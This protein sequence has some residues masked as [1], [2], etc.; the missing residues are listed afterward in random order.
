MTQA[1][2]KAISF[3]EVRRMYDVEV[4]REDIDDYV[5]N[6]FW[7]LKT[8]ADLLAT[9]DDY[10]IADIGFMAQELIKS[11]MEKACKPLEFLCENCGTFEIVCSRT[12]QAGRGLKEGD[13]LCM[14]LQ[15]QG[16]DPGLDAGVLIARIAQG[17]VHTGK[18]GSK[19]PTINSGDLGKSAKMPLDVL[20]TMLGCEIC[21]KKMDKHIRCCYR[22]VETFAD[23]L[24]K[25][26]DRKIRQLGFLAQ[27]LIKAEMT[28]SLNALYFL[29]D[30]YGQHV[31]ISAMKDDDE[32]EIEEGDVLC[33]GFM[34]HNDKDRGRDVW[35]PIWKRVIKE[36]HRGNK[37]QRVINLETFRHESENIIH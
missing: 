36:G 32:R 1:E 35:L 12:Y 26:D 2:G 25:Q 28:K 20:K 13:I 18:T 10:D 24:A 8:F 30:N 17:K 7:R 19:A 37:Q 5:R 31:V 6:S 4:Y 14:R 15:K 27:A 9:Y 21:R 11:E 29:R 23:L 16:G 3:E 34:P 22:R 33:L